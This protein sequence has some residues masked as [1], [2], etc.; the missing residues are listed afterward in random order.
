METCF[1]IFIKKTIYHDIPIPQTYHRT[2]NIQIKIYKKPILKL[3]LEVLIYR[4]VRLQLSNLEMQLLG[5]TDYL[6][7]NVTLTRL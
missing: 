1:K 5:H 2:L 6:V 4:L 3:S 7:I